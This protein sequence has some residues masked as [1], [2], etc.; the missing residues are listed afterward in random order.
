MTKTTHPR[1]VTW[2]VAALPSLLVV[3]PLRDFLEAQ[4]A[5]HML[6]EIP[7]LLLAGWTLG[8]HIHC[9]AVA[10]W[11]WGSWNGHGLASLSAAS[12]ILAIW[13]IPAAIDLSLRDVEFRLA[14]YA[15]IYVAG[16]LSASGRTRASPEV[17]LFFGGNLSWMMATL[18]LYM[19]DSPIALCVSYLVADQFVTGA[20]LV[21]VSI[22]F[23]AALLRMLTRARAAANDPTCRPAERQSA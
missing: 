1:A 3:Q 21:L 13:M 2:V 11:T 8:A 6:V 10:R 16:A 19:M 22:A 15:S 12:C 18:G 5:F 20:G 7:L 17:L 4:M 9:F 14:K 23:S